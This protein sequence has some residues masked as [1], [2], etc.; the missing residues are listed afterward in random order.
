MNDILPEKVI[1]WERY[2]VCRSY[3]TLSNYFE[4]EKGRS[5]FVTMWVV[6]EACVMTLSA[7]D[8]NKKSTL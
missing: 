4:R 7:A 8:W 5:L 2:S 1:N 6:R 3:L